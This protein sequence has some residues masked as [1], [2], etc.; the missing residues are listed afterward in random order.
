[1]LRE[2]GS[3]TPS[4]FEAV[5]LALGVEPR[6][7]NI[8][9]ELPSNEAVR[10]AVEAGA[11]AKPVSGTVVADSIRAGTL[12]AVEVAMPNRQ[13]FALRHTQRHVTPAAQQFARLA[14]AAQHD[15]P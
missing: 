10:L 15:R 11:G 7:L 9:L 5:L 1:V 8:A 3:G 4:M 13:F 12:V 6:L 2:R 14:A